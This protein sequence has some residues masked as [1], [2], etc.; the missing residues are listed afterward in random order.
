MNKKYLILIGGVAV[1]VLIFLIFMWVS[2]ARP[3]PAGTSRPLLSFFPFAP[4]GTGPAPTPGAPAVPPTIQALPGHQL[5]QLTKNAV[6]GATFAIA[7][8]DDKTK[9]EVVRYLEKSTGNIY[10]VEPQ[11]A[12]P[13]R[14]SNATIAK[15]FE[16]Y[17]SSDGERVLVRY[18]EMSQ[19]SPGDII[20]NF[21]VVSASSTS[22]GVFFSSS[23]TSLA[24][25][26]SENK[27]FYLAGFENQS[28]GIISSFDDK[29]KKQI[30]STPFNGF[31]ADWPNKNF[32]SLNSAASASAG[33]F[34]YK[35]NV[36]DGSLENILA[37]IRG[38]T[39]LWSPDGTK[40]LYSE[41]GFQNIK[42]NIYSLKDKTSSALPL[43]TLPEKCVWSKIQ[44]NTLY[45]AV[46]GSLAAADYPDDWYRGAVSFSDMIWKISAASGTTEALLPEKNNLDIDA[47]NLRLDNNENYLLFQNKKDG[48]LWS[49]Q[50]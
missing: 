21:S 7:T 26:P 36:G 9:I 13:T 47:I 35:L 14:V 25:S 3:Q 6:S 16:T 8:M 46:P 5:V 30:F 15:I 45:C 23:I 20:K 34:L 41:S 42:T 33:G 12:N 24:P 1:V 49:L 48:A 32:I 11:G 37:N 10:D 43:I 29:N 17:W 38:L 22:Q 50:I 2:L 27:I 28:T 18:P 19:S 39:S 4:S 31:S 44:D 40:I